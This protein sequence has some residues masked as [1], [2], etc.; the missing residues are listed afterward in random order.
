M[1][2]LYIFSFINILYLISYFFFNDEFIIFVSLSLVFLFIFVMLKKFI[3]F[4]YYSLIDSIYY[5]FFVLLF[6]NKLINNSIKIYFNNLIIYLIYFINSI[7]IISIKQ[8][9]FKLLISINFLFYFVRNYNLLISFSATVFSI[10]ISNLYK[11]YLANLS[12]YSYISI[13]VLNKSY[14]MFIYLYNNIFK[15]NSNKVSYFL[16]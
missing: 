8:L 1:L 9:L 12:N 13:L 14:K 3:L 7:F 2:V 15:N 4:N 5:Y 16:C 11:I 10:S 6:L